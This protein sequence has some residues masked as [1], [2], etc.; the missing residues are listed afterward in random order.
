[1]NRVSILNSPVRD[2]RNLTSAE[3][4][5]LR[6]QGASCSTAWM[7][8]PDGSL[9]GSG[10]HLHSPSPRGGSSSAGIHALQA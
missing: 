1:M 7:L 3:C 9:S 2:Y 8:S 6:A 5:N 10:G 4:A